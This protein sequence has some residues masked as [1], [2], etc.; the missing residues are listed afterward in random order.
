MN[1]RFFLTLKLFTLIALMFFTSSVF[2]QVVIQ[3]KVV[4][5]A[6]ESIPGVNIIV[7]G[8]TTG[9]VTDIDG[10]FSISAKPSDVLQI[11]FIGY[12]TQLIEIGSK[13]NLDITLLT[14]Q[15]QIDEVM[16]VGYGTQKKESVVGAITQIGSEQLVTSGVQDV[17]QAITG[18][19][20]GVVTLQNTGQPGADS[21]SIMIRGKSTWND[22]AP[23][24]M[25]DGIER[26][27]DNIDPNEIETISV[28]KDASATAVYGSKG[29][30]GVI[31]V[32]TKRGFLSKPSVNFT[33]SQGFKQATRIPEHIDAYTTL[34][35]A[36]VAKKNEQDWVR[37]TSQEDLMHYKLQDQPY[38]YPDVNWADVMLKT[39]YTTNANVNLRG[40]SNFVKYFASVGY[41]HDGDIINTDKQKEFDPTFYSDRFNLRS[42]LDFKLTN[43]TTL[44]S[45]IAGSVKKRNEMRQFSFQVFEAIFA[46]SVNYSPVF[47][48]PDALEQYPDVNEPGASGIRYAQGSGSGTNPYTVLRVGREQTDGSLLQ[49]Q[50]TY[51]DMNLNTDVV[52]NQ[53]LN[54]ITKGL[55][56]KALASF[57]SL[58]EYMRQYS[59]K[60]AAYTLNKDGSWDR[61]PDYNTDLEPIKYNSDNI[62]TYYRKLYWEL[63]LNYN[64]TF[65]NSHYVTAMA[66]FNRRRNDVGASEPYKTESWAARATYS[67]KLKYL[68]ELNAGYTGSEQFAPG[69]RFGFFPAYAIGWNIGEE[70][71]VKD[72]IDFLSKLK[73]RYSYGKTGNDRTN[74][75]W[76]YYSSYNHTSS[77]TVNKVTFGGTQASAWTAPGSYSEGEMPNS[78]AQWEEAEKYNLGFESGLFKNRLNFSVDLFKEDRTGILMVPG[79]VQTWVQVAFKEQNIGITKTHGYELELRYND[80]TSFGLSYYLKSN[81]SFSENRVVFRDEAPNTPEHLKL[82][83]KPIGRSIAMLSDGLCQSV[84][85]VVNYTP[86]TG[87]S[88]ILIEGD[89]RYIDYNA[90]GKI[91]NFDMV[92]VEQTSYPLYN[93]G[94]SHGAEYKGFSV[95]L[96]WQGMLG[97]S[98]LQSGFGAFPFV[99]E[100]IRIDE[101]FLDYWTPENRDAYYPSPRFTDGNRNKNSMVFNKYLIVKSD[102][103]RLKDLQIAYSFKPKF[104]KFAISNFTLYVSGNNL[105]TITKYEGY[106]DPEGN[107]ASPG[108]AGS[109]PLIKRYNIGLKFN[110]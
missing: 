9:T 25:V 12:E 24:I 48:G 97:K 5:K 1:R 2:A 104:E 46:G 16:V 45:N 36:N 58:A 50:N 82:R 78:S 10:N 18:K 26:S 108:G 64:R 76:L 51:T 102:F 66:T 27:F 33:F 63:R 52:L 13:T 94:I 42:N 15:Q 88:G 86:R 17:A 14:L 41:L 101:H 73:I 40:G 68:L 62:S 91:D 56:F 61:Y 85:D 47:Y 30:N 67:Y 87:A 39:G 106:D 53:D 92:P 37:L 6:G 21:P 98:H 28:L 19:L 54:F 95:D 93:Y 49:Q 74:T 110:F 34:Q 105:W 69:N 79:V 96:V 75:R 70:S 7:V 23:L 43:T 20:S 35:H 99:R 3:G 55:K 100:R 84:D 4:D 90:D 109:Y 89:I 71:F 38:L 65:A 107:N 11:S 60:E 31:L 80:K 8:T 29:A 81:L 32:T 77:K 44:S 72:N 83:G 57:T 22:S 59:K 103:V